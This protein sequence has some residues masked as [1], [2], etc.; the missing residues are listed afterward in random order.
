MRL[1][2]S[3]H[4]LGPGSTEL[5]EYYFVKNPPPATT[6]PRT[7]THELLRGGELTQSD[8]AP[9]GSEH[10]IRWSRR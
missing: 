7:P 9:D 3:K 6:G 2:R 4:L 1:P 8:Q 5:A 10:S